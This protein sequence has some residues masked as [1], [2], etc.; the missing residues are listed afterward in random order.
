MIR[1]I[2][3]ATLLAIPFGALA[4]DDYPNKPITLTVA[5]PPGGVADLTARPL[6]LTLQ[7]ILKQPV[8]IVNRPGAGG[9]TGNALIA[10]SAPDG[11]N[12][13]MALSS[14]TSIPE[15]E[16]IEGKAPSY[17]MSQFA[18][19]AMLTA[20]PLY[21]AVRSDSPIKTLAEFVADAKAN[22]GKRS[23]SSSGVYG[24]VHIVVEML[25]HAAG[26]QFNHVPYQ[27]GGPLITALIGGQVDFSA[28]AMAFSAGHVRSGKLRPLAIAGAKR[29]AALPDVPTAM[30]LGFDGVE[31]YIWTALMAPIGTPAPI[32][33]K[34]RDATRAAAKDP[35]FV[36][37]LGKIQTPVTYL[38]APEF[39]PFLQADTKRNVDAI[40]RM[41][42]LQATK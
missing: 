41:G 1:S 13:L 31:Y 42:R 40:K 11:Y 6:A 32:V 16:R 10:K 38:D 7:G 23:Y 37:T 25:G 36:D 3:V 15:A 34:L 35:T 4:Q 39:Q 21:F 12:L 17:E 29:I 2:F 20:D 27:G 22:P 5:F 33:Q 14:I 9:A 24:N 19:I 28:P 26:I 8:I 18:P 30:E